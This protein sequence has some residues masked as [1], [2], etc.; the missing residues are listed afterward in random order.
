MV[1]QNNLNLIGPANG[2]EV[3]VMEE[4]QRGDED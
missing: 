1:P 4:Y 3:E 2:Q